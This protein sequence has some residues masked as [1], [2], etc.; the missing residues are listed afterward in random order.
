M[1]ACDSYTWKA[2]ADTNIG[3]T[4]YRFNPDSLPVT[5]RVLSRSYAEGCDSVRWLNLSLAYSQYRTD[6]VANACD[7]L[8]WR[9]IM[10]YDHVLDNSVYYSTS[11]NEYGCDTTVRLKVYVYRSQTYT[12]GPYFECDS[13]VWTIDGHVIDTFRIADTGTIT[14]LADWTTTEKNCPVYYQTS[15]SIRE[16][17]KTLIPVTECDSFYWDATDSLYRISTVDTFYLNRDYN[18]GCD[19]TDIILLTVGSIQGGYTDTTVCDS[20]LWKGVWYTTNSLESGIYVADDTVARGGGLCDSIHYYTL[21]IINTQ[22]DTND[23]VVCDK[24]T[25]NGGSPYT[26]DNVFVNPTLTL[27]GSQTVSGCDSIVYVNFQV[28]H[29]TI[30]DS[31]VAHACDTFFFEFNGGTKVYTDTVI[32]DWFMMPKGDIN[33]CDSGLYLTIN[34]MDSST[35]GDSATEGC[36]PYF[37]NGSFYTASTVQTIKLDVSNQYGCDSLS[38][39][40][41]TVHDTVFTVD[42]VDFCGTMYKWQDGQWH[43]GDTTA[44]YPNGPYI[45]KTDIHGCDSFITLTLRLHAPVYAIYRDSV[46]VACD[47]FTWSEG[48]GNTYTATTTYGSYPEHVVSLGPGKCDSTTYLALT[49]NYSTSHTTALAKCDQYTWHGHLYSATG[50]Y[51]DTLINAMGCDSVDFLNL[52]INTGTNMTFYDTA[53]DSYT[54]NDYDFTADYDGQQFIRWKFIAESEECK[55]TD[56]LYLTMFRSSGISSVDTGCASYNWTRGGM[57]Y[58]TLHESGTHYYSYES[59][60]GCTSVDTLH[61]TLLDLSEN[62]YD[63]HACDL[64]TWHK[65]WNGD[66]LYTANTITSRPDDGYVKTYSLTEGTYTCWSRD[67]F[68]VT[69][70]NTTP[71]PTNIS[72]TSCNRYDW[73]STDGSQHAGYFD[74]SGT[75]YYTFTNASGCDSVV[76]LT[77]TIKTGDTV[78]IDTTVCDFFIYDGRGYDFSTN[79]INAYMDNYGCVGV[80]SV[81]LTVNKSKTVSVDTTVCDAFYWDLTDVTYDST[82]SVTDS[83]STVMGCDS[84]VTMHLTVNYSTSHIDTLDVCDSATWHGTTYTT[85]GIYE[86]V[87]TNEAGCTAT[88][89]LYLTVRNNTN[90]RFDTTVCDEYVWHEASY[91]ASGIYRYHYEAENGCASTDTLYLTVNRSIIAIDTH[92]VCDSF[93]WRDSVTYTL[94][95]SMVNRVRTATAENCDSTIY[96]SLTVKHSTATTDTTRVNACDMYNWAVPT[97]SMVDGVFVQS[98]M[99]VVTNLTTPGIHKT[100]FCTNAV[101]CDSLRVLDLSL[102]YR[103]T[104]EA[105]MDACGS[106]TFYGTTYTNRTQN[107]SVLTISYTESRSYEDNCDSTTILL[108]SIHPIK[109]QNAPL[110]DTA[111]DSYTWNERTYTSSGIYEYT[112]TTMYDC[113]S[114]VMLNLVLNYSDHSNIKYDTVCDYLTWGGMSLTESGTYYDTLTTHDGCDSVRT[115]IL[116][117]VHSGTYSTSETVCDSK[118]WPND[119]TGDT[120]R[121]SMTVWHTTYPELYGCKRV[122]TLHLTVNHS[123][124]VRF[125]SVACDSLLWYSNSNPAG[126]YYSTTGSYYYTA[127]QTNVQ[128]CDSI[129]VMK[130]TVHPTLRRSTAIASC[131]SLTWHDSL[132]TTTRTAVYDFD[133]TYADGI[134]C[135]VFDTLHFTWLGNGVTT[136]SHSEAVCDSYTWS[137]TGMTYT[138][139]TTLR[140]TL[141]NIYGC[142]SNI[143]TL[144]LTISQSTYKDTVITACDGPIFWNDTLRTVSGIYTMRESSANGGCDSITVMTLYTSYRDTLR[145]EACERYTWR[146]NTYEAAGRT[147]AVDSNT[148]VGGCDSSYYLEVNIMKSVRDTFVVTEYG[149]SYTWGFNGQT[150]TRP[151][152]YVD[153][154][155]FSI[156][157]NCG[158]IQTLVLQLANVP[159]PQIVANAAHTLV[160]LNHYPNGEDGDRVDYE[161]YRW[162]V[163]GVLQ[164]A[165]TG[166]TY[167]KRDWTSLDGHIY[168]IEVLYDN[169]WLRSNEIDLRSTGINDVENT[170]DFTAYPNPVMSG[171]TLTVVLNGTDVMV[172]GATLTFFDLQGRTVKQTEIHSE[173]TTVEV[174]L[175]TGVY[176]IRVTTVDGRKAVKK[177]IVR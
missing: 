25:W 17:Q 166:D 143:A 32:R 86:S 35:T 78:R 128:G 73:W 67:T 70:G 12:D 142:D 27:P 53:C 135:H 33:G 138:T 24:Y 154:T 139:D 146:G 79:F 34:V 98:D 64:F 20:L 9:G 44:V 87:Y 6:S 38:R 84:V 153:T 126:A 161:R 76:Q 37:W 103:D 129:L 137:R 47:S 92:V 118:V 108:L 62:F 91:T 61:L 134:S 28:A 130:L 117:V 132:Y 167:N 60:N 115:L 42:S 133:S 56:T 121:A 40:A 149:G 26:T 176:S 124:Y 169:M 51:S 43:D 80:D 136:E 160:M 119:I 105:T 101:G 112:G 46:V 163:D 69:I 102:R 147:Y 30:K 83:T 85:S 100:A 4:T 45:K 104:T 36:N 165:Y 50:L 59:A 57:V 131:N 18:A 19:S 120:L 162:Y 52:T 140:D 110:Y 99:K 157:Y 71:L 150:Y 16:S 63:V 2:F 173:R 95:N 96:L 54:W 3:D 168:Y 144:I 41:I 156:A 65:V 22:R 13:L 14:R 89:T 122:D 141:R 164:E 155:N 23:S 106:Y 171:R 109:N 125:D 74:A 116:T 11:T 75:Y 58:A 90:S 158:Y 88:D 66:T 7:S 114:V 94:S 68:F 170:V 10:V 127:H 72:A 175:P 177:L 8:E 174:N 39:V 5:K 123:T 31:V 148:T 93:M 55:H 49:V 152:T 21:H 151:G 15:L 81:F 111:C 77:L 82:V 172:E 48:N 97:G 145:V 159:I 113:D 107:D 1:L 29:G